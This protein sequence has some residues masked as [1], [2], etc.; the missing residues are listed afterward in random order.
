MLST[1]LFN[2]RKVS[3]LS[4]EMLNVPQQQCRHNFEQIYNTFPFNK[5]SFLYHKTQKMLTYSFENI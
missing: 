2:N 4:S 3:D 1:P 5:I